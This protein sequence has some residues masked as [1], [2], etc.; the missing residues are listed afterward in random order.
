MCIRDS[1]TLLPIAKTESGNNVDLYFDIA[2]LPDSRSVQ[3]RPDYITSVLSKFLS[4]ADNLPMYYSVG[5]KAVKGEDPI[6]TVMQGESAVVYF[7]MTDLPTLEDVRRKRRFYLSSRTFK[8][9]SRSVDALTA[10]K[11]LES[12]TVAQTA[13]VSIDFSTLPEA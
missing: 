3:N 13:T 6:K 5:L 12:Q 4:F 11:P 7:D 1:F 10:T 2:S 8:Y 9:N